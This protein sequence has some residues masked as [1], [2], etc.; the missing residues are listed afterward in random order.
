MTKKKKR[1][2][3]KLKENNISAILNLQTKEDLQRRNLACNKFNI[4][5]NIA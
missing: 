5:S 2:I 1:D 4:L 3:I